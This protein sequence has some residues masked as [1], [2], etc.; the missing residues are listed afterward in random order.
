[1]KSPVT[2]VISS[3]EKLAAI[4]CICTPGIWPSYDSAFCLLSSNFE[5]GPPNDQTDE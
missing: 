3:N 1:M 4:G 5:G 2:M